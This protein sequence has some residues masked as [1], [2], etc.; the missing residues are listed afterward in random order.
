MMPQHS[1]LDA[2]T[3]SA[4]ARFEN[5]GE[6]SIPADFGN[7]GAEYRQALSG[8]V[9]FDDSARGK[10]ELLGPEAPNFLQNMCTNDV[11]NLPL[12]A[13]CEAF[14]C[15]ATAKVVDF[16]LIYHVR[17]AGGQDAM[18]LDV[19]PGRAQPLLQHLERYH[20][21]ERFEIADKS[22]DFAQIHLAGPAARNVLEK[23]LGEAIPDLG[24]LQHMERTLGV[25]ATCHI[26]RHDPLGVLGY[27]LVCLAVRGPEVWRSLVSAG[28]SPAGSKC[29]EILRVEAG[30]PLIGRDMDESRFVLEVGRTNAV[31][32]SKGC[33]LGQEPIVMSRDRA[34]HVNRLLRGLKIDGGTPPPPQSKAFSEADQEVAVTTSAVESP[35]FG[36][37]ALAYVRRGSEARS[38]KLH[39]DSPNGRSALV[40]ALPFT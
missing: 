15:T 12:G 3:R 18:W 8:A 27:D 34:G 36:P 21:A 19:A 32:Y 1:P 11:L 5:Q 14:F 20:I 2:V 31:S 10:L 37:I 22:N 40:V 7:G 26:R 29:Q 9:L 28:A 13:G 35:R 30:T 17:V 39:L 4:G 23:A 24:L 16:A 25:S 6:F 33:Y 38:T